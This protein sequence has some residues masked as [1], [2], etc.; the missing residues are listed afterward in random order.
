MMGN[1]A[2]KIER[3]RGILFIRKKKI[4][5]RK[6][7]ILQLFGNHGDVPMFTLTCSFKMVVPLQIRPYLQ[8]LT[9][10]FSAIP[11]LQKPAK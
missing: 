8:Y 4:E 1:G 10:N 7:K 5:E 11:E 3:E 9:Q 2:R 6:Q